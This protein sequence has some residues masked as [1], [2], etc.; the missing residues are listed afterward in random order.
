MNIARFHPYVYYATKYAFYPG[1]TSLTRHSYS[2]SLYFVT[3]GRGVF[4]LR[5]REYE[6]LPGMMVY[7]EAG[8]C[9]DWASDTDEPMTHVCC[10]FD[11]HYV[12]RTE[13]YPDEAGPICYDAALLRQELVGEAFPYPLPEIADVSSSLRRWVD[14][15]QKCYTSN[16][17]T[18]ERTFIPNM[19]VQS[20][21]LQFI[22]HFLTFSLQEHHI[23]DPRITKLLGRIEEDLLNGRRVQ[24]EAYSESLGLSRGYFFELFKRT[25]GMSPIQYINHSLM[26][27]AKDDL[28]SSN[29]SIMQIADKYHFNSVHYFSRLFRQYTGKSPQAFR[30]AAR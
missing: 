30:G 3:E 19:M 21:F 4:R 5:G 25:T 13:A 17:H 28:R 9:H 6:A 7:M 29:L 15:M 10:Y 8:Q 14:L 1:Q 2:A 23:P 18:T 20:H 27:R 24:M 12:D 22:D 16:E 11:W 26:N